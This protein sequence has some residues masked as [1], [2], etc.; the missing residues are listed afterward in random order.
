[1]RNGPPGMTEERWQLHLLEQQ[2]ADGEASHEDLTSEQVAALQM[3]AENANKHFTPDE[4]RQMYGG[5]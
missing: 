2:I 5:I 4:L 1:M 3:E